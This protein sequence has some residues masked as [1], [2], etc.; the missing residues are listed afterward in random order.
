MMAV[1]EPAVHGL[2]EMDAI[3]VPG[4]TPVPPVRAMSIPTPSEPVVMVTESVVLAP[5]VE[6][7]NS[8]ATPLQKKPAGHVVGA[9]TPGAQKFPGG[10][11]VGAPEPV[12]QEEPAGQATCAVFTVAAGQ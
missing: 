11:I 12:G 2:G 8:A 6:P 3:Y 5:L 7:V 10:Q 4:A 9:A 1:Q